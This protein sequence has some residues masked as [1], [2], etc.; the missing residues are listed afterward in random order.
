MEELSSCSVITG[1]S[2]TTRT[3]RLFKLLISANETKNIKEYKGDINLKVKFLVP[4][5]QKVDNTIH[6]INL[7]ETE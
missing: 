1:Y 5:V 7:C 4:F 3:H 6:Q 2:F